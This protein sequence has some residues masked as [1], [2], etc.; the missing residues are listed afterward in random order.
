[1]SLA[2][3]EE[4]FIVPLPEK[5]YL[6]PKIALTAAKEIIEPLEFSSGDTDVL[7][8]TIISFFK[9]ELHTHIHYSVRLLHEL[10]PRFFF[11]FQVFKMNHIFNHWIWLQI[12]LVFDLFFLPIPERQQKTTFHKRTLQ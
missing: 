9:K 7:I 11:K 6:T 1:M 3:V 8:Q 10:F 4:T 5:S 2:N 12:Y